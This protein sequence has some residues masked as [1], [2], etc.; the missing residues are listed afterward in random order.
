MLCRDYKV[1]ILEKEGD[2]NLAISLRASPQTLALEIRCPEN[3][4]EGREGMC[5]WYY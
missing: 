4:K 1:Y 5:D 3:Q 2:L